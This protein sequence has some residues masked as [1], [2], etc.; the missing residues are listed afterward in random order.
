MKFD[1]ERKK[2]C[3]VAIAGSEEHKARHTTSFKVQDGL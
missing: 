3:K 1:L 2:M